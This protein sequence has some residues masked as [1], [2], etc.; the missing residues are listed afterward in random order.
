[1]HADEFVA[2]CKWYSFTVISSSIA[3]IACNFFPWSILLADIWTLSI[4]VRT[5]AKTDPH[6]L[7]AKN[8]YFLVIFSWKILYLI[9]TSLLLIRSCYLSYHSWLSGWHLVDNIWLSRWTWRDLQWLCSG[10]YVYVMSIMKV[11]QMMSTDLLRQQQKWKDSLTEI[12]QIIT[13]LV[14]Q[15]K[16]WLCVL[17]F[18]WHCPI[19]LAFNA[20][21]GLGLFLSVFD[22][23][24]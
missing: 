17:W 2:V 15:V 5:F 19:L 18:W 24:G 4:S 3:N 10:V 1:M 6:F 9:I 22:T 23:I 16:N 11:V 21:V 13:N 12:R 14:Q 20:F 8:S 7:I